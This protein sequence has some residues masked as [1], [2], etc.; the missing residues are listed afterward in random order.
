MA[1]NSIKNSL[2]NKAYS[3]TVAIEPISKSI[4]ARSA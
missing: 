2:K 4:K 1:I 3:N